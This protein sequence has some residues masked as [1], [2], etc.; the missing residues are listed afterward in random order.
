MARIK[1]EAMDAKRERDFLSYSFEICGTPPF[2]SRT[3]DVR[4][5]ADAL[6]AREAYRVDAEASGKPLALTMRLIDGRAPNGFKAAA[7]VRVTVN[8]EPAR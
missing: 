1:L 6:H 3:V 5:L 7:N 2:P 8:L 4:T